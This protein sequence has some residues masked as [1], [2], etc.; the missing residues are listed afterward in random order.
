MLDGDF[1]ESFE[2]DLCDL[3]AMKAL[4][5]LEIFEVFDV[6]C[7]NEVVDVIIGVRLPGVEAPILPRNVEGVLRVELLSKQLDHLQLVSL[8]RSLILMSK[9]DHQLLV[10]LL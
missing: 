2:L 9:L 6:L 10:S 7:V 1:V 5:H 8:P 3:F 4:N